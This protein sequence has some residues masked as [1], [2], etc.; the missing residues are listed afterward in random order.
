MAGSKA[1][2]VENFVR[3]NDDLNSIKLDVGG[4]GPQSKQSARSKPQ[5]QPT[6]GADMQRHHEEPDSFANLAY[7][8]ESH[9]A[10]LALKQEQDVDADLASNT[11][12]EEPESEEPESDYVQR[13]SEAPFN[14]PNSDDGEH[15]EFAPPENMRLHR[16]GLENIPPSAFKQTKGDSYPPTTSGQPSE[17]SDVG[18]P[19]PRLFTRPNGAPRASKDHR[20]GSQPQPLSGRLHTEPSASRRQLPTDPQEG[21][22]SRQGMN[23]R[24]GQHEMARQSRSN[25]LPPPPPHRQRT[26]ATDAPSAN[27]AQ[28]ASTPNNIYAARVEH[29]PRQ[30]QASAQVPQAAAEQ[31]SYQPPPHGLKQVPDLLRQNNNTAIPTVERP[32]QG[33]NDQAFSDDGDD[34]SAQGREGRTTGTEGTPTLH[35]RDVEQ[36]VELD[37]DIPDLYAMDYDALKMQSFDTDPNAEGFTFFGQSEDLSANLEQLRQLDDPEAQAKFFAT[38]TID[39]WEQCGDWFLERFGDLM[40]RLREARKEKREAAKQFEDEI[41]GRHNAIGQKRKVID[42]ALSDMR[43][44]GDKLLST[45]PKKTKTK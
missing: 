14:N 30:V 32:I 27:G 24:S 11:D 8:R 38:L 20:A 1:S 13:E 39:E 34:R 15:H 6:G 42:S 22:L 26:G 29:R 45:T 2:G 31:Q 12:V 41:A 33:R 36:Q 40:G 4:Q 19:Q 43:A 7:T 16:T 9:A 23:D 18:E 25:M 5:R 37:Y 21:M 17:A 10:S 35:G 28:A 3:R 44:N